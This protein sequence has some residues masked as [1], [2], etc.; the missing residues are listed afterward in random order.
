MRLKLL[1]IFFVLFFITG[2]D[3][4]DETKSDLN[5]TTK[6]SIAS[7]KVQE[8]QVKDANLT[9]TNGQSLF[10]VAKNNKIEIADKNKA[11]LFVFWATWCAPCRAEIPHLNN[12]NDKFKKELN[13]IAVLIENKTQDQIKDFMQ[14]HKIKYKVAVGN[15]NFKLEKALGGIIGLPSSLLYKPNGELYRSYVGLVPEEMLQRDILK[16]VE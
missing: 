5:Q 4:K 15:E 13:I 12:L 11:T 10:V 7:N 16:A 1:S 3:K 14:K 6:E 2:C 9:L 8:M